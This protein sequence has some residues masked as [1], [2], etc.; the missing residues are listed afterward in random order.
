MDKDVTT[1]FIARN[2]A[3]ALL[4]IKPFDRTAVPC[5]CCLGRCLAHRVTHCK[6]PPSPS[7]KTILCVDQNA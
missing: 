1:T 4:V 6:A 5:A 2:K 7:E 3:I